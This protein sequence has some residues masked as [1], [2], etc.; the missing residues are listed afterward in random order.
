MNLFTSLAYVSPERPLLLYKDWSIIT[1][2]SVRPIC[3]ESNKGEQLPSQREDMEG[4]V[5]EAPR[6]NARALEVGGFDRGGVP[7]YASD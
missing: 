5:Q 1:L 3:A 2:P 7:L 4:H 6:R